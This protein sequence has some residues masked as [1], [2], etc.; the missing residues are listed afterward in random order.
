MTRYIASI[1]HTLHTYKSS[2][3][4]HQSKMTLKKNFITDYSNVPAILILILYMQSRKI[5]LFATYKKK[6]TYSLSDL[7]FVGWSSYDHF[8]HS[9]THKTIRRTI[10]Y[11]RSCIVKHE[12]ELL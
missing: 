9:H 3:D 2:I 7:I 10:R 1:W 4:I 12:M 11:F 5:R 8:Y 6:P